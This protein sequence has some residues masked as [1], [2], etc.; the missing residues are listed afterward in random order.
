M[1]SCLLSKIET[2]VSMLFG[3]LLVLHCVSWLSLRKRAALIKEEERVLVNKCQSL[4]EPVASQ[5]SLNEPVASLLSLSEP[6]TSQLSLNEPVA[7]LLSLNEPVTSLLSLNEP[8]ASP[9][10]LNEPVTSL[11]SLNEPV[12]S[13][14]MNPGV[15]RLNDLRL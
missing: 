14:S 13:L 4:N 7:S 8:V 5:L 2:V 9:L 12:A 15:Q 1:T 6:V 3:S 11:L 10:S